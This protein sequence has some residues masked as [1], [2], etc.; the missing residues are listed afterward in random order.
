MLYGNLNI[1]FLSH[2][3]LGCV[4]EFCVEMCLFINNHCTECFG[5]LLVSDQ[6]TKTVV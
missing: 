5:G 6:W 3:D 4:Y 2:I 1:V